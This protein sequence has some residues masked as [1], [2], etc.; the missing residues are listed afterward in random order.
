MGLESAAV[1]EPLWPADPSDAFFRAGV[2]LGSRNL[3]QPDRRALPSWSIR[4]SGGL[5]QDRPRH[6]SRRAYGGAVAPLS[7]VVVRG[8]LHEKE[9]FELAR[10]SRTCKEL[11]NYLEVEKAS[12]AQNKAL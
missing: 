4:S 3:S 1:L 11:R 7:L 8:G 10:G 6:I 12:L 2:A 5:R 9:T